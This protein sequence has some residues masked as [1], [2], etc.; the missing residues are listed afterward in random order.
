MSFDYEKVTKWKYDFRYGGCFIFVITCVYDILGSR[1][2]AQSFCSST[3]ST[4][5]LL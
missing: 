3:L 4:S 1:S 2:R 5:I